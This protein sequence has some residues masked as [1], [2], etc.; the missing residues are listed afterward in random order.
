[1]NK[2]IQYLVILIIAIVA[3]STVIYATII[4]SPPTPLPVDETPANLVCTIRDLD[5]D[6]DG[7]LRLIIS[8]YIENTGTQ[9][10]YNVSLHVQTWFPNGTL[11]LD[12][13]EKLDDNW[14]LFSPSQPVNITGGESYGL[15][16][17]YY[18]GEVISVPYSRF[19]LDIN[20]PYDLISTY[21]ITPLWDVET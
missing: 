9:T 2:S 3:I 12:V 5:F 21:K 17:R 18:T 13:I 11:G 19:G 14:F 7:G 1:M 8:G 6:I 4:L 16:S 10:A 20:D 15:N